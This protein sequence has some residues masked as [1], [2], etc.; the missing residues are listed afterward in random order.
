MYVDRVNVFACTHN[1]CRL[2]FETT[3]AMKR[4]F[5]FGLGS[6][7]ILVVV[8]GLLNFLREHDIH[9]AIL[10]LLLMPL[11]VVTIRAAKR[12]PP[13]KSRRYAVLGWLLGFFIIHAVLLGVMGILCLLYTSDAADE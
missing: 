6:L 12:A 5:F 4:G 10:A 9:S 1:G 11:S 13:N 8:A 2:C 7:L 3:F